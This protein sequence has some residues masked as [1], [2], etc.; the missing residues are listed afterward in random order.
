MTMFTSGLRSKALK[1]L[2]EGSVGKLYMCHLSTVNAAGF[3]LKEVTQVPMEMLS[4]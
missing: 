2:P 1:A 3:K 4:A